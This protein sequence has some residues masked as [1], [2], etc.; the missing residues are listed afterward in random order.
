MRTV[1]V[2][3]AALLACYLVVASVYFTGAGGA[4][5]CTGLQIAVKDS[6]EK[7]FIDGK[8][9]AAMLR[10]ASLDPA[11]Q[12]VSRINTDK[13]ESVLLENRM[14]KQ[15]EAYTTPSGLVRVEVTQRMPVLR[16]MSP[17]GNYY[18]DSEGQTMPVSPR[19]AV[20]VPIATGSVEKKLALTGL[21]EFALFL[22]EHEFWNGQIDQIV[23]SSDG[24]VE[25][26][27]RVG[28]HRIVLG[29]LDDFRTKLDNLRLFYRQA[30]PHVGWGKYRSINLKYKNQIVCTKK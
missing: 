16:V 24:E 15:A 7:H 28:D 22:Q 27:P 5:R 17:K 26:I 9:V 11:G 4:D 12:P 18:V 13:I 19:Y 8:E 1:S 23:V 29:T 2:I 3:V 30:I 20:H 25:L 6:L 14:I 10:R 21:Y